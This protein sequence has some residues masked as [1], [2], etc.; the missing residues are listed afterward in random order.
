MCGI[1]GLLDP[2]AVRRSDDAAQLVRM[3]ADRMEARGPDGDG[4]WVE[5]SA[6]IAFGHRRLAVIDLTQHGQ[7]P[8]RSADQRWVLTYNGEIYD[9]GDVA[10]ELRAA[11]V[12]LRGSSDTEVLLEAIARW[13]LVETLDRVDGMFALGLWDRRERRLHLARDR[14]GEKPLYFGRLGS[15]EV[16]FGSSLDALAQHPAFDTTIDRDAL[17]AYFRYK[18]V[19]APWTIYRNMAKLPPGTVVAIEADGSIGEP[20]PYWSLREKVE[21]R[22]SFDGTAD[23]AVAELDRLLRRSVSRRLFADVPVGAFL[24]GGID[25]STVV[26]LAQQESAHPVRT[27]TIGSN[28]QRF[29]ESAPARAVAAHLGTE[30]RELIVTDADVLA[31]VE[32][33]GS[34][35]DEPFADSSQVPTRLVSELARS[36]VTV[37]LS[38]DGGDELFAGYN[39]HVWVPRVWRQL[40]RV[41][42]GLRR[43][44]AQ[45]VGRVPP[46]VWDRTSRIVPER[47]RPRMAGVKVAKLVDVADVGSPEELYLRL[48]T[49]WGDPGRL[50]PGATEPI[51]L[52]ADPGRWPTS[53]DLVGRIQGVDAL[54]YLPDDILTKVDRASMSVSLEARVP[55]LAREVVEFAFSLP[56]EVLLRDGVSKWPLRQVL[57]RYVPTHLVDR[58]KAGFGLPLDDWLRGG[59]GPW[60]QE[61]LASAPVAAYLDTSV[62]QDAWARHRS[63]AENRAY[64]LWDVVMFASW[65]EA[66]GISG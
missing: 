8:M 30:H 64:E 60:A 1:V 21:R 11:G 41:P 27:F 36:E 5:E 63:G 4:V 44:A 6:G 48:V 15:G 39:R 42:V 20:Q 19:P 40:E 31:V 10:A 13:G 25:S 33:L 37:A 12:R 57:S 54:T 55:L 61:R 66:R 52:A 35:Y 65:C 53:D 17:A 29:D 43:H 28:D 62:V 45:L 51:G 32:R 34:M 23:D 49:H 3:M 7:Q 24:S 58:P 9:H 46:G 56:T 18:Y 50:V 16:V 59:L 26:A 22:G 2:R 14:M 47:R 38:G